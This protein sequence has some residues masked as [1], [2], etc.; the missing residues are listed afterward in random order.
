[1]VIS[2]FNTIIQQYRIKDRE[3]GVASGYLAPSLINSFLSGEISPSKETAMRLRS[4][5]LSLGIP[6]SE[7]SQIFEEK[8]P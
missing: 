5:L 7:V 8:Y 3:L 4:G 6:E 1:M 2:K